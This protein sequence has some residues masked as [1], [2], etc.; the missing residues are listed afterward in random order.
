[1]LQW[2]VQPGGTFLFTCFEDN[3][4]YEDSCASLELEIQTSGE[5]SEPASEDGSCVS[6]NSVLI[7][8]LGNTMT[9]AEIAVVGRNGGRRLLFHFYLLFL[10]FFLVVICIVRKKAAA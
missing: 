6:G 9:V 1:M 7:T 3:L 10:S 4:R 5:T 2:T 8:E